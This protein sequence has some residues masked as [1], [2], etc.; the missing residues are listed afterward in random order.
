MISIAE[1]VA[2]VAAALDVE[3]PM[4]LR[5]HRG[6]NPVAALARAGELALRRRLQQ[7]EPIVA[8]IDLRGLGRRARDLGSEIER[9]VAG[10]PLDLVR[11]GEAV[12]AHPDVVRGVRQLRQHVATGIVGHDDLDERRLELARLGDDPHA[13]L[14]PARARDDAADESVGRPP[15]L[16]CVSLRNTRPTRSAPQCRRR[17]ARCDGGSS[18]SCV[19]PC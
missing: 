7:R 15:R 2:E 19:Y 8:G 17:N 18:Y 5:R 16:L 4:S 3:N 13:G 6:R 1:L 11:I 12:A 14:G 10:T 9:R